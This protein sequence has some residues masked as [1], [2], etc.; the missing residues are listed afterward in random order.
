MHTVRPFGDRSWFEG[1][2]GG[3]VT[4]RVELLALKGRAVGGRAWPR[5]PAE[6][7]SE[8]GVRAYGDWGALDLASSSLARWLGYGGEDI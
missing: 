8:V 3:G 2:A 5:A 6:S 7:T 1:P 4:R